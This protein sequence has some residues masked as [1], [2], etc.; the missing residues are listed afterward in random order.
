VYPPL[1]ALFHLATSG[2]IAVGGATLIG[3]GPSPLADAALLAGYGALVALGV[4]QPRSRIF[5]DVIARVPEGVAL[6]F[7]D[8]PHP[9]HTRRILDVLDARGARAT[10]F[11]IGRKMAA[12]PGVVR[13]VLAR[14]HALGA[15]GYQHDRLYA[16]RGYGWLERDADEEERVWNDVVGAP[17][18]LFRPPIGLMNP[19]IARLAYERERTV[20]AWTVR[21]RDG[22]ARAVPERVKDRAIDALRDGAIVLMHDAA[23]RDDRVPASIAAL[24]AILDAMARLGLSARSVPAPARADA[25]S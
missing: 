11:A 4:A 1:R 3:R 22:V 6:T 19:R 18:V 14:G 20:V 12:H 17:P 24:P 9:E 21:T 15:H 16:L 23:E 5:G 25:P 10:F 7:D 13:E 2:A 8:G